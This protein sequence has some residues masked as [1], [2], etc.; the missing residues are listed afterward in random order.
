MGIWASEWDHGRT[1]GR[2]RSGLMNHIFFNIM[3]CK[4]CW[5]IAYIGNIWHQDALWKEGKLGGTVWC[6]GRLSV[7][8]QWGVCCGIPGGC[9]TETLE[10]RALRW[11]KA[12]WLIRSNATIHKYRATPI[13]RKFL[14]CKRGA[15]SICIYLPQVQHL[16]A[17]VSTL[18]CHH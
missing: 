18:A 2:G 15:R 5:C 11:N 10:T 7:A 6:F 16:S 4:G 1:K 17:P 13:L 8:C 12:Y 3:W 14:R 9:R